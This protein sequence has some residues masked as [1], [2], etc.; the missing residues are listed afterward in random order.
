[1]TIAYQE[2]HGIQLAQGAEFKNLVAERLAVDPSPV[3]V[4]R[5]WFNTTDK[6][7]KFST[8]D[9]TGALIVRA[10]ATA[11]DLAIEVA[12]RN[13]AILVESTRAMGVESGL[14]SD[15]STE[16][17]DRSA[18][19]SAT[20]TAVATEKTRSMGV[21]AGLR[22][23]LATEISDRNAA[24]SAVQSA[25]VSD[26]AFARAAEAA[27]GV[28]VDNIITNIDPV[29]LDSLSELLTAFQASDFD[30]TASIAALSSSATSAIATEKAAR[31]AAGL[32]LQ[33]NINAEASVRSAA[34]VAAHDALV[35]ETAARVLDETAL[36]NAI[37]AEASSR[38]AADSALDTRVTTVEGQVN[39][40]IGGLV[41]LTTTVK[42]NIVAAIDEVVASVSAEV[43][44]RGAAITA[45]AA[46]RA[47]AGLAIRSDFNSKRKS[48]TSGSAVLE[49]TFAHNF[50]SDEIGVTLWVK[51]DDGKYYNDTAAVQQVDSNTL[52]VYFTSARNIKLLVEDFSAI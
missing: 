31:E 5:T 47:T 36:Q 4:G 3:E 38:T 20:N 10:F 34:I 51:R 8:V 46:A 15:L 33:G 7:F 13:A 39:G 44:A 32:V 24:I 18:A 45:E 48:F 12:A 35:A 41:D 40:K 6:Q 1:M 49:H 52:K 11:E 9:S 17:S 26:A 29:A 37:T 42:T 16:I 27:L 22:T 21:E 28:R 25:L 50:S 30:L 43:S 14:R 2:F 23:D 19:I